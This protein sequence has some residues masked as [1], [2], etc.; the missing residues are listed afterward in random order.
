MVI[1]SV[2]VLM[3]IFSFIVSCWIILE[4]VL[5]LFIF[6]SGI[7]EYVNVLRVVNCIDCVNLL[8]N[9]SNI[10]NV[11]GVLGVIRV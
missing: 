9:S 1:C 2:K 4:K 10:I 6:G 5:V 3:V 8:I 11:W 7:L